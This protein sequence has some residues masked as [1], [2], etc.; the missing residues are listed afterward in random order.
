[1]GLVMGVPGS[2]VITGTEKIGK[3]TGSRE[4]AQ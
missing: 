3:F 4:M 2:S 1:M